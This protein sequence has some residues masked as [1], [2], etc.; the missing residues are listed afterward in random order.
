[1]SLSAPV[2]PMTSV[3]WQPQIT[4]NGREDD[5]APTV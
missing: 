3:A 4:G 5:G 2:L 1:M